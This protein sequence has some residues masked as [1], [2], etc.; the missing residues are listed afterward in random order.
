[1]HGDRRIHLVLVIICLLGGCSQADTHAAP[2]PPPVPLSVSY[3]TSWGVKGDG[4]GQLDQPTCIATDVGGD[5]YIA[6]AGSHFIEKFDVQGT[7][8]LAFQEDQLKHPQAIAVDSGGAIY[9]ADSGRGSA[10]VFLPSGDRFGELH[11]G[12][13]PNIEDELSVAVQ[14]DGLIHVLDADAGKVFTFSPRFRLLRTWLPG[15]SVPES[16]AH[17]RAIVD[18]ADGFLYMADPGANR[19]LRFTDEGRFAAALDVGADGARRK[20]SDQFAV[21][22]GYLFIMDLNG[23]M[24][25]VWSTDG[26]SRLDVDLAPELG[27]GNRAA[28]ALA[29]SP[30]KELL[31]LDAPG[32]RVL[33]YRLN[34]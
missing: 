16:R 25:H 32:A 14:D 31:V 23:R 3:I 5:A 30:R 11:L 2:Q 33:R 12:K 15:T 34:F 26:E 17:A 19:I 7:P 29:V 4:P 27:E 13:R 18:G 21:A 10:V 1:M 20:L 6:D 28:P 8:L 22:R 24:L 9:V